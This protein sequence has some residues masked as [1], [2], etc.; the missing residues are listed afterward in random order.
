MSTTP[1]LPEGSVRIIPDDEDCKNCGIA[2]IVIGV[3]VAAG[4]AYFRL[5]FISLIFVWYALIGM[6][7]L[8]A[9]RRSS[10]TVFSASCA[11]L[12]LVFC[13]GCIVQTLMQFDVSKMDV[14]LRVGAAVFLLVA[15]GAALGV[16]AAILVV[17]L[18]S[19][20]VPRVSVSY[21]YSYAI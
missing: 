3:V 5:P 8:G 21:D 18:K 17:R 12:A 20:W 6:A 2:L 7:S 10:N 13:V 14:G 16:P 4:M 1:S 11:V 15:F 9:S 19:I